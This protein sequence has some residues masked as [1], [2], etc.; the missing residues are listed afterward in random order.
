VDVRSFGSFSRPH[1][2]DRIAQYRVRTVPAV[3]GSRLVFGIEKGGWTWNAS[4]CTSSGD[5]FLKECRRMTTKPAFKGERG[6]A[7]F[8]GRRHARIEGLS[9]LHEDRDIIVVNKAPGLLT[10]ATD[11]DRTRTAYHLL[12]DY[13]RKGVA[14]SRERIFIVHRLDRD[15]SGVLVFARNEEAKRYLQS[16]WD[17]TEKHY[18]AVVHG[19]MKKPE[20]TLTSYLTQNTA[21]R[22]YSTPD[23]SKGLLSRTAYRVL[24]TLQGVSVLDVNLLTGRKHQIRVH[25]AEQ[26]NPVIGDRKYGK[27]DDSAKLLALHALSVAITHPHTGARMI[28]TADIPPHFSRW[29]DRTTTLP[30]CGALRQ[31]FVGSASG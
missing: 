9:I 20:G 13:V 27:Q 5:S 10:I 26:G 3:P 12:T 1:P 16:H 6:V 8:A 29:M 19:T 30:D 14:K 7:Q 24:R 23:P 22:V 11:K 4:D 2:A 25:L 28:F 18:L 15:T 31:P 21:L 17:T